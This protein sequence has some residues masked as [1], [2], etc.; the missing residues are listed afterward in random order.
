MIAQISQEVFAMMAGIVIILMMSGITIM[1]LL[2]EGINYVGRRKQ[3]VHLFMNHPWKIEAFVICSFWSL[4]I[5][6]VSISVLASDS[7]VFSLLG[8]V[9]VAWPVLTYV[10]HR[11]LMDFQQTLG[12]RKKKEYDP[13]F[14]ARLSVTIWIIAACGLVLSFFLTAFDRSQDISYLLLGSCGIIMFLIPF[15]KSLTLV[16]SQSAEIEEEF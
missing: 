9:V 16:R 4:P 5:V 15:R 8:T 1:L 13:V 12:M 3:L 10:L 6:I 2:E 14:V 7:S 11:R